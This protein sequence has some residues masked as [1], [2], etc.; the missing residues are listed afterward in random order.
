M[1]EKF[2][3]REFEYFYEIEYPFV[4][5]VLQKIYGETKAL[6]RFSLAGEGQ[7]ILVYIDE[8]I[9]EF[10]LKEIKKMLQDDGKT[11]LRDATKDKVIDMF[12]SALAENNI[13]FTK[14][15]G[16]Y[17]SFPLDKFV[18][19]VEVIKK[20]KEPANLGKIRVNGIWI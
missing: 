1:K 12:T 19:Q 17:I 20:V 2:F 14:N 4:I 16:K 18:I 8:K 3:N 10:K 7:F 6:R 5:E 13:K 15:S 9:Y 11:A